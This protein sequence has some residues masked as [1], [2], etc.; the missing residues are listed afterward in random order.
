MSTKANLWKALLVSPLA[1]G[2]A[3]TALPQASYAQASGP[4]TAISELSDVQPTDW[5]FQALQSLVERYGC[6]AG[7]PDRTYRGNR[8]MTRFEFAAGMN[9][10]LDRINELIA[11]GLADKVSRDDLATLQR[12]QE[13]FA[14]EL[15]A[16]KGRVDAL[17][18]DVTTLKGQVFNPVTK[19]NAQV[20]AALVFQG[21]SDDIVGAPAGTTIDQ[22]GIPDPLGGFISQ[23]GA[24]V[25]RDAAPT[26]LNYRVRLNF[27]ASFVPGDRL[28][29]R[30]QAR[31]FQTAF[32]VGDPGL[33]VGGGTPSNNIALDDLIYRFPAFNRSVNFFLGLNSFDSGDVTQF[34]LPFDALSDAVDTP[35]L[36]GTPGGQGVGFS[37]KASDLISLSYAYSSATG[38]RLGGTAQTVPFGTSSGLFAGESGHA[39]ELGFTPAENLGLYLS[40][41][42]NYVP[43]TGNID[44]FS[45][46]VNWDITP[47][48]QFA[49]WYSFSTSLGAD[50]NG[51]LVGL[52]FPDLFIEGAQGGIVFTQPEDL[53]AGGPR[54]NVL[55]VYYSFPIS[56][57]ITLTPG[58]YI[59]SNPLRGSYTTGFPYPGVP[60]PGLIS[61]ANA[62]DPSIIV[63]ALRAT[64]QF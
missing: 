36:T 39:V 8:A 23:G 16:L 11:A 60:N 48:V 30:L 47:R 29:I 58:F 7:Y 3:T 33:G 14:A 51:F 20:V 18:A 46:G 62:N 32:F 10:C 44:G 6:I 37:W 56:R 34:G 19:L 50:T 15:A 9:A 55:D 26:T 42:S 63:G 43:G 13:E 4:V 45:V 27:D 12:L 5:A 54:T 22:F 40:Y 57:F 59:V 21:L 1:L 31:D 38:S 53:T 52:A 24:L 35:G 64:F 28:R 25:R 17:E 2:A 49:G 41:A 61:V